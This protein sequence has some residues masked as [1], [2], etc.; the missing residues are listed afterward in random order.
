VGGGERGGD[1][2]LLRTQHS[3]KGEEVPEGGGGKTIDGRD[4]VFLGEG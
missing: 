2:H 3:E 1:H 4:C